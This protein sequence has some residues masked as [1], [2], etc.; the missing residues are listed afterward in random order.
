[1]VNPRVMPTIQSLRNPKL[2]QLIRLQR[3]KYRLQDGCFVVETERELLRAIECGLK[4]EYVVVTE[5]FQ[6][7]QPAFCDQLPTDQVYEVAEHSLSR[8][9]YR[10]NPTGILAVF[11]TPPLPE[12]DET[13]GREPFLL[14]LVGLRVPGNI[15]A[16]LRSADALG[17]RGVLLIDSPLDLYNPNLIRNST[18]AVFLQNIIPLAAEE[19][20][21]HLREHGFTL[22]AAA[23]DGEHSLFDGGL[24]AKVALLLGEEQAGLPDFWLQAA[25]VT[26]RIP[27][28]G[29]VVDSLNVAACGSLMMYE[30]MRRKNAKTKQVGG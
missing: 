29:R 23:V 1:M 10:Q 12:W 5:Q 28:D 8:I 6:A 22:I 30:M 26:V 25:D 18:G 3:K 21:V 15:G 24:P 2:Q 9:A 11:S 17:V 16:L 7:L 13:I 14:A 27:M 4:P 19:A 20:W